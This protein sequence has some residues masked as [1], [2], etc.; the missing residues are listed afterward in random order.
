MTITATALCARMYAFVLLGMCVQA[1]SR[2]P[3]KVD[4]EK[5]ERAKA[6]A[7]VRGLLRFLP[8]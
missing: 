8:S 6:T 1:S 5:W 7:K 2:K 3:F 4:F